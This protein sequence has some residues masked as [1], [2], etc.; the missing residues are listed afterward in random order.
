MTVTTAE[1][2]AGQR[3]KSQRS[4]RRCKRF[5]RLA[6]QRGFVLL[7]PQQKNAN[8]AHGCFDWF[9]PSAVAARPRRADVCRADDRTA[10]DRHRRQTHCRLYRLYQDLAGAADT[11]GEA[12]L[13]ELTVGLQ[14]TARVSSDF[15][16]H[17]CLQGSEKEH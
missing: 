4:F 2:G 15:G 17:G 13:E 10:I 11:Q 7:Y 3:S 6:A 12:C 8:D 1:R 16:S 9:Q 14:V 5:S